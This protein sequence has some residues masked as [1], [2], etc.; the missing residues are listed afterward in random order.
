[1]I[2][3]RT[4]LRI[5]LFGGGTD[6]DSFYR[7]FGGAVLSFA[8]N[9]YIYVSVNDKFDGRTR[10]SYSVTENVDDPKELKHDIVRETL[11]FYNL[12]GLEIV[13]VSDIPGNGTGLGSSSSFAVGLMA[14]LSARTRSGVPYCRSMLA[15][16]AYTIEA[17]LCGHPCGKQDQY[18]ASYGGFHYYGFNQDGTVQVQPVEFPEEM[19]RHLMLFWTGISRSA[20]EILEAQK[21]RLKA[22]NESAIKAGKDMLNLTDYM[23]EQF[24]KRDYSNL[25]K[26]M[27]LSWKTKKSL[28]PA[29]SNKEIDLLYAKAINAGAIGGKLCGAGGGGFFLFVVPP[30]KQDGLREALKLRQVPFKIEPEGSKVIYYG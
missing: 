8:I 24:E 1:M 9:K 4:P 30:E 13:S 10:V 29:A 21:S 3:T 12:R 15:E 22:S 11:N 19:Q 17:N 25:G 20:N 26:M 18:A 16:T 5:S 2:V 23:V 28:N 6:V 7:H 27:H 14:A